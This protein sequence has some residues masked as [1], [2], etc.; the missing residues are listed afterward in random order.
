MTGLFFMKLHEAFH[1]FLA[2]LP[3]KHEFALRSSIP[4]PSTVFLPLGPAEE[5]DGL[6]S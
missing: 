1:S 6:A 2:D 3:P 4:A 5:V